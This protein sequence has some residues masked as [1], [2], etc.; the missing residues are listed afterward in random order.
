MTLP[1]V[2]VQ[3]IDGG[4]GVVRPSSTGVLA[5]IAPSE[6]GTAN[7][8]NTHLRTDVALADLGSGPL[9]EC[10]AYALPETGNPVVLVKATGTTAAAY[11]TVVTTGAGSSVPT[12]DAIV[13]PFDDYKV[14]IT[15]VAGGTVGIT[16]ITYKYSLDDG[17]TSSPE[18][19]LG[20]ATF[21]QIPNAG[22]KINLA[23][24]TILAAE[25]IAVTATGPKATNADLVTALEA[26]RITRSP[27]EMVLFHGVAD[28]TTVSNLDTWLNALALT[29]RFKTAVCTA[30]PRLTDGTETEAQYKTYLQGLFSSSSSLSVVVCAD[31]G[32]VSSP[33]PGRSTTAIVQARPVGWAVAARAMKIPLG[34]DPAFG[35]PVSQFKITDA[36]GN[37][38]HHDE[39]FYPGLDDLRLTT[40][41]SFDQ[42]EGSFIT[43]ANIISPAG[44]D[45]VYL[46]H[47]RTMNRACEIGY[48]ILS[49]QLSR[50][51]QKNPTPGPQGQRYIA[52]G[53]ALRI[54]A[55]A[56]DAIRAE[57]A[58][59]VDDIRFKVSRTDNIASNAGA[60]VTGTIE[61]VSLAYIKRF[62]VTAGFV[63]TIEQ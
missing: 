19:S 38:S 30:R 20:T 26:L 59:Q 45:Y 9:V 14:R 13:L 10:A 17:T 48:S 2:S 11:G 50:G 12:A 61:S 1:T 63:K 4:T 7:Q 62:T 54:E 23:A 22:V 46:Q 31:V 33:I 6:K 43:N 34:R 41:R 57:L 60:N 47:A 27:F 37:P 8:A 5:I 56:N 40:L 3:K 32:D 49:A 44:S 21:I 35:G 18:Q 28:A 52:E 53:E 58:G 29:G 42:Q 16:G 36:R 39:Y 15:F 25:T 24:G 51:V 55:V